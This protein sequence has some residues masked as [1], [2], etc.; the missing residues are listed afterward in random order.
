MVE[1]KSVCVG[2]ITYN[3]EDTI[4]ETLDSIVN[5]KY[6]NIKIIISDDNSHDNTVGVINGWLKRQKDVEVIFNKNGKNLGVSGNLNKIISINTC[7]WIKFLAGD[8]LLTEDCISELVRF[9]NENDYKIISSKCI[10]FGHYEKVLPLESKRRFYEIDAYQQYKYL[11]IGNFVIAPTLFF[12]A[13]TLEL[14]DGFSE[15]FKVIEDLP[16]LL[17]FTRNNHKI[18]YVEK[19]LVRYRVHEKSLSLSNSVNMS[20]KNELI[21]IQKEFFDNS[22]LYRFHFRLL[23]ILHGVRNNKVKSLFKLLSPLNLKMKMKEFSK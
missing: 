16:L 3:S 2:V 14:M 4:V 17:K 6:K 18:G 13:R 1:N 15:R 22:Y 8:D 12:H 11:G 20:Y 7:E 9:S 19:V 21:K 23:A 10:T 5:Q